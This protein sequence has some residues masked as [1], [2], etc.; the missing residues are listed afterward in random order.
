MVWYICVGRLAQDF[1]IGVVCLV[2]G[3]GGFGL[4]ASLEVDVEG[5]ES[6]DIFLG[7]GPP[8]V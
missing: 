6:V 5:L 2:G 3:G 1:V 7:E 8:S 4:D